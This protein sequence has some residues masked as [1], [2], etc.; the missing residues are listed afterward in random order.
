VPPSSLGQSFD[1]ERSRGDVKPGVDGASIGVFGAIEDFEEGIDVL[2]A[3]ER[4]PG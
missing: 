4:A 3:G 2:A 1:I